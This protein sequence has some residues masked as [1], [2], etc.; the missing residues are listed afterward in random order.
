[1]SVS[2]LSRASAFHA[3]VGAVADYLRSPL[4]LVIRLYWGWQFFVAG[5]GKLMNLDRTTGFFESLSIPAPR[6]NAAMAGSVEC[7]GGLLLLLGLGSRIVT[8]PLIFTMGV[9][10]WTAD[11]EALL[12]VFDKPDAFFAAAPFL[13]LYAAVIVLAFGPGAFSADALLARRAAGSSRNK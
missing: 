4:L 11:R 8:I 7:F 6:V 13:F 2:V 12:G 9:A 1:M 3:K 10:Y 5:K